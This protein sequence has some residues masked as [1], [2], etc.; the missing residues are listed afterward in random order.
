MKQGES[1]AKRISVDNQSEEV[2]H[3]LLSLDLGPDGSILE[4]EGKQLL[5]ISPIDPA[6]LDSADITA[7][8]R[9]IA[10]MENGMGRPFNDID[11]DLRKSLGFQPHR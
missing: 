1:I 8:H 6:P 5:H 11:N 4:L 9:G 2:K 7:L 3:F 10:Q